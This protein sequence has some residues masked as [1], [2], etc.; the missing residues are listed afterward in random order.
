M[1]D[2]ITSEDLHIASVARMDNI[3]CDDLAYDDLN[4]NYVGYG[5][6]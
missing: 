1:C 5:T 2:E 6:D 4:P 3:I